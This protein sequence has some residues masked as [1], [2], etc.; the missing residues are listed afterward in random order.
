M[1]HD[2]RFRFADQIGQFYATELDFP[3]VAGRM[4]GF[5]AV[6]DPASQSINDLAEALLVTRSAIVQAVTLLETCHLVRRS[7]SRGERVDKITAVID[8]SIFEDDLDAPG[9]AAQAVLLRQGAALLDAADDR[10]QPLEDVADFYEFIGRR[11][12]ELKAEWR[13]QRSPV[14]RADRSPAD[15]PPSDRSPADQPPAGR[16]S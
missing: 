12:P 3:P 2:A 7:R 11:L 15:Q 5:L 6:C 1:S 9:H 13:A 10:R 8:V 14:G 16:P 4:L